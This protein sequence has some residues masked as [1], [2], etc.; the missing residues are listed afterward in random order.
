MKGVKR[1][2]QTRSKTFLQIRKL[3]DKTRV[4]DFGDFI[5]KESKH[6]SLI[7]NKAFLAD[8]WG[9]GD[10]RQAVKG[11]FGLLNRSQITDPCWTV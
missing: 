9:G 2:P 11:H 6:T 10:R 7:A 3:S 4:E 5:L 1:P 8:R